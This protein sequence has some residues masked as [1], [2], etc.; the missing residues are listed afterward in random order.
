MYQILEKYISEMD[1]CIHIDANNKLYLNDRT[2]SPIISFDKRIGSKS[3]YGMAY[4][5]VGKGFGRLLKF[6]TKL[7]PVNQSNHKEV[8][9]L[10]SLRQIVIRDKFPHF[11][12][13]YEC[14]RCLDRC[15]GVHCPEVTKRGAYFVV[16]N[17]LANMDVQ[18]WLKDSH[19]E[20]DYESV[21]MQYIIALKYFHKEGYFHADTHLGNALIHKVT[22]GGY[23]AY[24]LGNHNIYVPNTGYFLVLWDFGKSKTL[25]YQTATRNVIDDIHR[26]LYLISHMDAY[27]DYNGLVRPP[28]Y[29]VSDVLHPA[30]DFLATNFSRRTDAGAVEFILNLPWKHIKTTIPSSAQVINKRAYK[31]D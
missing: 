14:V 3:V 28:A 23:W 2:G 5:N 29:L 20:A 10:S 6:S 13:M 15:K 21:I 1:N 18:Q 9:I 12:I 30:C 4:A 11:P 25:R 17:E 24:K 16:L 19:T 26:P 22:P 7:M 27:K 31:L 8:K